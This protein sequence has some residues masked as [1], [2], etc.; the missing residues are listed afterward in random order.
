MFIAIKECFCIYLHIYSTL[1]I[2]FAMN[3]TH[4]SWYKRCSCMC[5]DTL[6]AWMIDTSL[7]TKHYRFF[8]IHTRL[9]QWIL[10]YLAVSLRI[11]EWSSDNGEGVHELSLMREVIQLMIYQSLYESNTWSEKDYSLKQIMS[12]TRDKIDSTRDLFTLLRACSIIM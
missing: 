2:R 6:W 3:D 8:S 9:D 11:I 5:Y 1:C 4:S 7:G 10:Y 12:L